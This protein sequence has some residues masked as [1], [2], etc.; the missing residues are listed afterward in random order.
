MKSKSKKVVF[1]VSV[2]MYNFIRDFSSKQGLTMSEY[3]RGVIEY[4]QMGFLMGEFHRSYSELKKVF[5]KKYG[6]KTKGKKR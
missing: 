6:K 3:I 5:L 1:R 4:F 2:P